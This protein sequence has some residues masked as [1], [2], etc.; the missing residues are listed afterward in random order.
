MNDL[1]T[2]T[3]TQATASSELVGLVVKG[4]FRGPVS[5]E[6]QLVIDAGDAVA[7]GPMVMPTPA[8]ISAAG[9]LVRLPEGSDEEKAVNDFLHAFLPVNR[10]LREL[11]TAWQCRPDGSVNDHSD[12]QYDARIRDQL[13]DIHT[14]VSKMLRRAGKQSA[15]LLAYRDQL[16]VALERFDGGDTASLTSPLTDGYHTV[17]MWLHQHV[18]M[19]LGVTRAEDEALEEKLVAGSAE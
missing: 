5:P 1:A 19:M 15:D 2:N 10:R 9:A 3:S 6:L 16:N 4:M 12:A 18:L 11:C 14:D 13:D 17:W 7:K 8:G